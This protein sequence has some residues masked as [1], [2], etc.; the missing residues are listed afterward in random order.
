MSRDGGIPGFRQ[1]P[2]AAEDRQALAMAEK[3]VTKGEVARDFIRIE[4]AFNKMTSHLN[5]RTARHE[6]LIKT[7]VDAGL[8]A[9]DK[10]D[11]NV[12]GIKMVQAFVG[13]LMKDEEKS[14][15]EKV[16]MIVE[17]NKKQT[18]DFRITDKYFPVRQYLVMNEDN[19]SLEEIGEIA[20]SFGFTTVEVDQIM[21][22]VKRV[23]A[24]N[25]EMVGDQAN[26]G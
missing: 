12:R 14:T 10:Y 3:K 19:L 20:G 23:E 7:L 8:I 9:N 24:K 17:F 2:T 13:T 25:E 1:M 4:Q 26:R 16:R 6:A 15:G 18:D 11:L 21:A 22:D 5:D